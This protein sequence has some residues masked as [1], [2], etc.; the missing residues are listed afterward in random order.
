MEDVPF[1]VFI[2]MGGGRKNRDEELVSIAQKTSKK[3]VEKQKPIILNYNNSYDRKVIHMALDGD[4]RVY[5][6]S[7]GVGA[8]RK[9]MVLPSKA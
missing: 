3:V 8:N 6:K 9:L 2:D 1:R 7:V 4:K 5:T